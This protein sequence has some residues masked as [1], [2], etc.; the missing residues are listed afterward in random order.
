MKGLFI[1]DWEANGL[2]EEVTK[3][4]CGLFKE[5]GKDNWKLFLD[6]S[7]PQYQQAVN[8]VESKGANVKILDFSELSAWLT[9]EPLGLGCHNSF[10]Y[11]FPMLKKMFGIQ[12]DMFK[13]KECRGT[14]NDKPVALMQLATALK[15]RECSQP[16]KS[17]GIIHFNPLPDGLTNNS[18][19]SKYSWLSNCCF[20]SPMFF[21]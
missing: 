10:F 14:I 12:Y 17:T 7:H 13:D 8:F 9:T 5:F 20:N 16:F 19:V 18:S 15:Y 4:H 3:V 6:F 21:T 1:F 11:D 2:L